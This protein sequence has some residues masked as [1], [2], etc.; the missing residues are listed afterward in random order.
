MS[1]EYLTGSN[2]FKL[3]KTPCSADIPAQYYNCHTLEYDYDKVDKDKLTDP[4]LKWPDRYLDLLP[5]DDSSEVKSRG[6][7]NTPLI[8]SSK[9]ENCWFKDESRNPSGCFKDRESA[10]IIPY[11]VE[12]GFKKFTIASSGNAALSASLYSS[13]YG[14]EVACFVPKGTSEGKK[15][16]ISTYG[17]KLTE[18][19]DDYE[20]CYRALA[21]L[22]DPEYKDHINIT[23]GILPIREQGDKMIAYEIW[24][25]IGVPDYI[26]IPSANGSLL[27]GIHAG[28]KELQ[29]LGLTDRLPVLIGVQIADADPI[30]VALEQGRDFAILDDILEEDSK[31]EG[32]V[33]LESYCSP[34]AIS[35]LK[36]TNGF[37]HSVREE[38]LETG[39]KYALHTEG[40]LPEWTA[41]TTFVALEELYESGK[42]DQSSKVVAINS[43]GG[44]KEIGKIAESLS[45]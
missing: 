37:I 11:L 7:G 29:L 34:N 1:Q 9:Y 4:S 41:A 45:S 25:E 36:E 3:E 32:L 13:I 10:V 39:M 8:L 16:L 21:D 12:R 17:G 18:Q 44:Q 22:D 38:N 31:A 5:F 35:A 14:C 43:G 15:I 30:R 28:F 19:G 23:S 6:E 2:K 40:L 24:S 20:E 42:I 33:A 27:S 26:V